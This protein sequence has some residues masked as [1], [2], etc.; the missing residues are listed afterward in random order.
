[1]IVWALFDDAD[2]SVKN[3]LKNNFEGLD[4]DLTVYSIGINDLVFDDDKYLYKKIDLSLNN[5]NLIK[6]LKELPHPDIIVASPP[7]KSW[8]AAA[9]SDRIFK[10]FDENGKWIMNNRNYFYEYNKTHSIR[11]RYFIPKEQSRIIGETTIGATIQIIKHFSPK[12][13]YIENPKSSKTWEFQEKHWNFNEGY[14]NG[15]YYSAYNPNFSLKPTIFKSNIQLNLS[16]EKTAWNHDHMKGSYKK[17][18]SIPEELLT[19]IFKTFFNY[20]LNYI[21]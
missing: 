5:F 9:G 4:L 10:G 7:C 17:R 14:K 15:T 19:Y 18:S 2:S 6:Q 11:K 21:I 20:I 3:A 8:S 12:F 16:K 1:M 13:W